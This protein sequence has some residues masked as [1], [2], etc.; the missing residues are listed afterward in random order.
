MPAHTSQIAGWAFEGWTTCTDCISE[1]EAEEA[2]GYPIFTT[3]EDMHTSSCDTCFHMFAC[4]IYGHDDETCGRRDEEEA[5]F[6]LA[7]EEGEDEEDSEHAQSPGDRL[8]A[9]LIA[10]KPVEIS[11]DA[12]DAFLE[13]AAESREEEDDGE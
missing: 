12:W 6:E 11:D 9:M 8:I 10:R 7:D 5:E 1:T 3:D 4:A 13:I 2:G